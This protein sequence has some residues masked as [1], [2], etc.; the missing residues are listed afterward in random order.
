[1]SETPPYGDTD[2][3]T[4]ALPAV[5][6]PPV[7]LDPYC[8]PNALLTR[9]CGPVLNSWTITT[10]YTVKLASGAQSIR[11]L[12]MQ[13]ISNTLTKLMVMAGN[14]YPY[15][16][17]TSAV[18][19]SRE[20]PVPRGVYMLKIT[21]PT[22]VEGYRRTP[23]GIV[24]DNPVPVAVIIS[25]EDRKFEADLATAKTRTGP[26]AGAW[27]DL[28]REAANSLMADDTLTLLKFTPFSVV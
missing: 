21:Y 9:P 25:D 15:V 26:P 24:C 27:N 4:A 23:Q 13:A 19:T 11:A 12:P 10:V 14:L 17:T 8:C 7:R 5:L 28:L 18:Q 3:D 20:T 6:V 16:T 1:M 2:I 22:M